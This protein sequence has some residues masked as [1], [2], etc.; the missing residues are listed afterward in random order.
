MGLLAYSPLAAGMLSGKYQ[1]D[2]TP[3]GTRRAANPD[4][5]GR[6]TPH[7]LAVVDAYLD[8]AGKHGLDACQMALAFALS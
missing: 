1:G 7:S 4:L 5:G 2:V 8:V 3:P 6:L